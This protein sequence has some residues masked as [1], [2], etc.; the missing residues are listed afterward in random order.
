MGRTKARGKHLVESGMKDGWEDKGNKASRRKVTEKTG[1]R[2]EDA[3]RVM[4]GVASI[5]K[6][7]VSGQI[8]NLVVN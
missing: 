4:A 2:W 1:G 8:L 3:G 7:Q 5:K 6:K